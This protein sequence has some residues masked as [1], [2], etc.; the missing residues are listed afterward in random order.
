MIAAGGKA[1]RRR[2]RVDMRKEQQQLSQSS[3]VSTIKS[4]SIC[5]LRMTRGHCAHVGPG[6]VMNVSA[7]ELRSKEGQKGQPLIG[8]QCIIIAHVSSN[9]SVTSH[10]VPLG[11]RNTVGF[12]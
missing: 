9:L 2:R 1:V 4:N 5:L 11:F 12:Y 10:S 8:C 7:G 3:S 6:G